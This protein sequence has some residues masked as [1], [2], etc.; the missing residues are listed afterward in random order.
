[1]LRFG[2][3]PRVLSIRLCSSMILV[4]LYTVYGRCSMH[5]IGISFIRST[6]LL[7]NMKIG[8]KSADHMLARE[9]CTASPSELARK[10]ADEGQ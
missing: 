3:L 10:A 5:S 2:P 7:K 8:R 6:F 1:M 9:C 4:F